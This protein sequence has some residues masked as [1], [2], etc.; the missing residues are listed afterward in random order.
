M[1]YND[2]GLSFGDRLLESFGR[3]CRPNLS[4]FVSLGTPLGIRLDGISLRV[5]NPNVFRIMSFV[6]AP[7]V[8]DTTFAILQFEP[9][10]SKPSLKS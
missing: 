8:S 4:E 9:D 6:E 10:G 3:D 7:D 1:S 5:L 2:S